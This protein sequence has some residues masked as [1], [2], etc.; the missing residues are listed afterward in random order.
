VI[1]RYALDYRT[2]VC[3]LVSLATIMLAVR[4]LLTGKLLWALLFAGVLGLFTPFHTTRLSHVNTSILDMATLAL[5]AAAPIIFRKS[6][7]PLALK[8][9]TGKL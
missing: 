4:S 2:L 8:H 3:I 9:P 7:V 5:F 1:F 6:A